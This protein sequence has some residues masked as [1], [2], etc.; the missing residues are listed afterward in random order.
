MEDARRAE[1]GAKSL[2]GSRPL[3]DQIFGQASPTNS[4]RAAPQT[5]ARAPVDSDVA[6]P[7]VWRSD[8]RPATDDLL[9]A[10]LARI[11][12]RPLGDAPEPWGDKV[13][14]SIYDEEALLGPSV[15]MGE[16]DDDLEDFEWGDDD[17][18][19][20]EG[21]SWLDE[22]LDE[23]ELP[24]AGAYA[25]GSEAPR[26]ARA[27]QPLC[28]VHTLEHSLRDRCAVCLEDLA[29]GQEAW[30]LPCLHV[31]HDVCAVRYLGTRRSL[32]T[33]PTCRCDIRQVASA[34]P[35]ASS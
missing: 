31:F 28:C 16:E 6:G 32:A 25:L 15:E 11:V 18:E 30:R 19:A 26:S 5:V 29:A 27:I 17:G 2:R 3:T 23:A 7:P 22:V 24:G 13:G 21:A 33:C 12:D 8:R 20:I 1:R 9:D 34:T 10:F 35:E 14:I 4:C